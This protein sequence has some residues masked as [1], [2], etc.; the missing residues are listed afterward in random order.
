V[1]HALVAANLYLGKLAD[2][3][4]K[5]IKGFGDLKKDKSGF[6][7]FIDEEENGD[8]IYILGVGKDVL[9]GKKS[10]ED[11]V[12]ILGYSPRDLMVKPV[13]L[14][15]DQIIL[16]LSKIPDLL[17]GK[18]CNNYIIPYIVEKELSSIQKEIEDFIQKEIE[19]FKNS[20]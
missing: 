15:N 11:L 4:L 13:C 14:K 19:D 17:G 2:R 8:K 12:Q 9:M 18:I 3:N 20:L 1:H 16:F 6:P 5:M 10:I 7:I